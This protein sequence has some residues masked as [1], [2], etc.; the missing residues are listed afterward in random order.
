MQEIVHH[1]RLRRLQQLQPAANSKQID[2]GLGRMRLA[3]LWKLQASM[4]P[5]RRPT[6]ASPLRSQRSRRTP[7][8]TAT[9]TEGFAAPT[10]FPNKGLRSRMRT[11]FSGTSLAIGVLGC[12]RQARHLRR[13][14]CEVA[15]PRSRCP[16][17]LGP[18]TAH[19]FAQHLSSHMAK[20]Q[21]EGVTSCPA[22]L[23]RSV[24][25]RRWP[26]S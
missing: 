1:D 19:W 11:R 7:N 8:T 15:S 26:Q 25:P 5:R 21:R 10:A 3:L 13:A 18:T 9:P 20:R 4:R 17:G 24:R 16:Y 14:Q 22:A 23:R 2:L 12:A 6:R